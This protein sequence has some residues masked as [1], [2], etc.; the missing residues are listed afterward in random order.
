RPAAQLVVRRAAGVQALIAGAIAL[1]VG[2]IH[3]APVGARV[4]ATHVPVPIVVPDRP[5]GKVRFVVTPWAEVWV[6]GKI[7]DTTPTAAPIDLEAGRHQLIL[8]NPYFAELR[9]DI[10]IPAGR[11]RSPPLP[12]T[13]SRRPG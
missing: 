9:R 5:H 8:R 3:L 13:P 2:L 4:T 12:Y 7:V 1:S 11:D 6:D 10:V